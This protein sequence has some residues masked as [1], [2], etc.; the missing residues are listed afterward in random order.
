MAMPSEM[1]NRRKRTNKLAHKVFE[2]ISDNGPVGEYLDALIDGLMDRGDS[3]GAKKLKALADSF[4]RWAAK[5]Y[6]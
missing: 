3:A 6:L 5:G 2:D 1:I 4:D